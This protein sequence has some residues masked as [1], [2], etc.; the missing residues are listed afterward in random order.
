MHRKSDNDQIMAITRLE[1]KGRKNKSRAKNRIKTIKRLNAVPVIKNV[2]V[3][4]I[5]K[6]FEAAGTV[7]K[8]EK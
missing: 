1:R 6:T 4:E 3:E 7:G 2:D 5:K 8:T